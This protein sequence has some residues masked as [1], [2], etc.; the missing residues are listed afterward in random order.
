MKDI[1]QIDLADVEV[2]GKTPQGHKGDWAGAQ[3]HEVTVEKHWVH[4]GII[5]L[6]GVNLYDEGYS[7]AENTVAMNHTHL[8]VNYQDSEQ[9][10]CHEGSSSVIEVIEPSIHEGELWMSAW[11]YYMTQDLDYPKYWGHN[12]KTA[13][14]QSC[15]VSNRASFF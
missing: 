6:H 8:Y 14:K 9:N 10:C 13:E 4:V 2:E 15:N 12:C 5:D 7:E 3:K 1:G 11:V